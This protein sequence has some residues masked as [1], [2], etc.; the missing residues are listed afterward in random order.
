MRRWC[1]IDLT[2]PKQAPQIGPGDVY[3][4]P[5]T[6]L[7]KAPLH[8]LDVNSEDGSSLPV[9]TANQNG[10]LAAAMLQQLAEAAL[11]HSPSD[12][13]AADLA[14]M[15]SA[16]T[17]PAMAAYSRVTSPSAT[18]PDKDQRE[19]LAARSP[20]R[21]LT[22]ALAENFVLWAVLTAECEARRVLKFS[23]D[24]RLAL[25]TRDLG[26]RRRA[27]TSFGWRPTPFAISTP[28][29]VD[30]AS[31]HL[32]VEAPDGAEVSRVEV[33]I[34]EAGLQPPRSVNVA[35]GAPCVH[36]YVGP[37]PRGARVSARISLRASRRGWLESSFFA[38]WL[39]VIVLSIA[40]AR[41]DQITS[42]GTGGHPD[43]ATTLLLTLTGVFAT[44]LLHR[45]EHA[46]TTKMLRYLRWAA[47]ISALL[48]Y[49]AA[50]VLVFWA[51]V[52]VTRWTW[53]VL[54]VVGLVLASLI[55]TAY[56]A[57]KTL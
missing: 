57:P 6:L 38:S 47:A 16:T 7:R 30:G 56:L 42:G 19:R 27:S 29:A 52:D 20:V 40:A 8:H 14:E 35:G 28:A 5:L 9:L 25:I 45:D 43:I 10:R 34:N 23:Y 18:A 46:M 54:A 3:L 31:Y 41:A 1:S 22:H 17:H 48:P 21:T 44:V 2:V 13:L 39:T 55:T 4:I 51:N 49:F 15:A 53:I 36:A 32:E 37:V 26:F 50:L 11:G 24:Q 12:Q 33:T